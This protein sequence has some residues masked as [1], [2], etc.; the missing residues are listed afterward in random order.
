M[1]KLNL[2]KLSLL[3]FLFAGLMT[4]CAPTTTENNAEETTENESKEDKTEVKE[5][6][7]DPF[8][9]ATEV[10]EAIDAKLKELT[11]KEHKAEDGP[12]M[13]EIKFYH[14]GDNIRKIDYA[15][16]ADH[17]VISEQ[18]YFAEDGTL[19]VAQIDKGGWQFDPEKEGETIDYNDSYKFFFAEGKT[20]KA[21]L[22]E[23]RAN[24]K[25]YEAAANK[26]REKE[27]DAAKGDKL[28]SR[29]DGAKALFKSGLDEEWVG[30][31][32]LEIKD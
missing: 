7:K 22:K 11:L 28:V 27:I 17:G 24:S 13:I 19:A 14:E 9:A 12:V 32:Y 25:E 18:Y 5:D 6:A 10:E 26:A 31:E 3:F 21:T 2:L 29:A 23:V 4:A 30:L 15:A 16:G 8:T 1:K 20:I